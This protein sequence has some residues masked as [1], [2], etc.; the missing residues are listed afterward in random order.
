[1]R[2]RVVTLRYDDGLQGFPETVIRDACAGHELPEVREQF[3]VHGN[4][5][6]L[7]LVLMLGDVCGQKSGGRARGSDPGDELPEQFKT[8]YRDLR[9]WRGGC[10][11]YGRDIL[12]MLPGSGLEQP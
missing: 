4:V 3:F 6:H 1:M 12:S 11:K 2:L 7:T 8:L 10:G 5:P 9:H